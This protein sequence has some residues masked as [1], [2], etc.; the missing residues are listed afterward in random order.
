[1][2]KKKAKQQSN[3]IVGIRFN[4]KTYRQIVKAAEAEKLAVSTMLRVL[5]ERYVE[6][7]KAA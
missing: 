4:E 3:K 2:Q 5:I 7:R 6:A 1:M